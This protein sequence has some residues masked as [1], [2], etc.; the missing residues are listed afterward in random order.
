MALKK[1]GLVA[2]S[3]LCTINIWTGAPLFAVWVG[4]KVQGSLGNLSM[5]AVFSVIL[6]LAVMVFA[7]GFL[8]TWINSRYDAL[9]G[10]PPA[11]RQTSP[12][13]RSMR[14]EREEDTRRKYGISP[15]ERVVVVSVV[16]GV[17]VF[18]VW[19]FFFAGSSLPN[20]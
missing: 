12:W 9:T 15:I 19:F 14:D 5:T 20:Q 17:L 1:V 8:L 2:A 6:V 16:A 3:A 13:L 18:E 4:S 11:A 10:R 7:L